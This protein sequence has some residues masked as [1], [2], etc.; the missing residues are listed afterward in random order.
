[1]NLRFCSLFL[2]LVVLV[3]SKPPTR[4][5]NTVLYY[6]IGSNAKTA[7]I[8]TFKAVSVMVS[9]QNFNNYVCNRYPNGTLFECNSYPTVPYLVVIS[10][11]SQQPDF[12]GKFVSS[13]RDTCGLNEVRLDDQEQQTLN[14]QDHNEIFQYLVQKGLQMLNTSTGYIKDSFN[15][16]GDR[17][18]ELK[19]NYSFS[20]IGAMYNVQMLLPYD[21]RL[22][23]TN[24]RYSCMKQQLVEYSL[25]TNISTNL[26]MIMIYM[27]IVVW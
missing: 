3:H 2:T 9:L 1:M 8:N 14:T 20:G 7:Q 26:F 11:F 22:L 4:I 5:G 13:M 25:A 27:L 15:V 10:S 12:H 21:Q 17:N 16:I 23:E 18:L 6:N 19:S 24:H